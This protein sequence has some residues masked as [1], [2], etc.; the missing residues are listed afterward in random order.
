[1]IAIGWL[2]L[3][4]I[5]DWQRGKVPFLER[6]VQANLNKLNSALDYLKQWALNKH[7]KPSETVYMS[8]STKSKRRLRFSKTGNPHIEQKYYTHYISP[9]LKE[10]KLERLQKQ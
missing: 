2:Q 9:L 6:V 1:M 8:H 10:K 4:A 3:A 5:K 7:L